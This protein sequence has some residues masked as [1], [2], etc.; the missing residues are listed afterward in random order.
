[1]VITDPSRTGLNAALRLL[2]TTDMHVHL[3]GYDYYAN[4]EEAHLGLAR[5]ASLIATARS[6]TGDC[7]LLDNGD[8][9]QGNPMGDFLARPAGLTQPRVHPAIRVMNRLGYDA[10]TLGNHEFN[11]GLETLT[12]LLRG[13]AFPIVSANIARK[14]GPLPRNDVTYLSAFT[15]LNRQV[16]ASDGQRHPLRIGVIGFAPPQIVQWDR[17]LLE[18]VL[19]TRDILEAARDWVPLLRAAGAEVVV[20]L[21]HSGIGSLDACEGAE[22]ASAALARLPGID[23]IIAGHSH[24]VFPSDSFATTPGCDLERGLLHGRPLVMPGAYGSHLGVID[25]HLKHDGRRWHVASGRAEARAV[26]KGTPPL[27]SVTGEVQQEHEQTLAFCGRNVG[28]SLVRL[29]SHFATIAAST[30][31][32]VVAEAQARFVAAQVHGR[33]EAA[34]PILSAVSPF[35]AGGR[36]GAENYTDIPA[37]DL[38]LRHVADLYIFPNTIVAM[39]LTGAEIA[40]WLEISAGLYQQI[41]PGSHDRMLIDDNFPSYNHDRITRLSFDIDLSQPA[42]FDRYGQLRNPGNRRVRNLCHDGQ[43]LRPEQGFLLVTNSYR[44]TGS[45][46]YGGSWL[47]RS[48]DLGRVPI[49]DILLRHVAEASPL[50]GAPMQ[51]QRFLPMPGTTVLFDSAQDARETR[52][53]IAHLRPEFLGPGPGGFARFRLHL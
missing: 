40:D 36:G 14:L 37:G 12:R 13:A 53:D 42:R 5:T 25:L 50:Q 6:E 34:L 49:R 19:H 8:F 24:L 51:A 3:V 23:A 46:G 22:N 11:Y 39:R 27:P 48:L 1:M 20:A 18:G 10:A 35:K 26:T 7:L 21:S 2:A 38:A 41:V 44:A 28:R 4:R 15:L 9:L 45:G 30:A 33:P 29:H 17:M 32:D 52:Q 43:P 47:N 31:L 16:L